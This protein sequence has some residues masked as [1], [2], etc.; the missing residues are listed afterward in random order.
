MSYKNTNGDETGFAS[1]YVP[2]FKNSDRDYRIAYDP[3]RGMYCLGFDEF[4]KPDPEYDSVMWPSEFSRTTGWLDVRDPPFL[5]YEREGSYPDTSK[6]PPYPD[7]DYKSH[8]VHDGAALCS[9]NIRVSSPDSD[10]FTPISKLTDEQYKQIR[11]EKL[12]VKCSDRIALLDVL[13]DS[14]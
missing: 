4:W 3:V 2:V 6:L 13:P 11:S 14:E 10:E 1:R 9:T 12:C 7:K 8:F 5:F